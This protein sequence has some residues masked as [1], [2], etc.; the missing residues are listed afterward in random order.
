MR[1]TGALASPRAG[2]PEMSKV[3]FTSDG[4]PNRPP[5]AARRKSLISSRLF[6]ISACCALSASISL[7]MASASFGLWAEDWLQAR[8]MNRNGAKIRPRRRVS[9]EMSITFV[10]SRARGSRVRGSEDLVSSSQLGPSC[11]KLSRSSNREPA[12]REPRVR[13]ISSPDS[14]SRSDRTP[15][16]P[17]ASARS[18]RPTTRSAGTAPSQSRCRARR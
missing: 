3:E 6:C 5:V 11:K 15:P 4:A 10:G 8:N 12:N 14:G 2:R 7:R 18:R 9:M 1:V 16:S 13:E 17:A